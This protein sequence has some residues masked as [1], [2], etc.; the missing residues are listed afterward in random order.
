[1]VVPVQIPKGAGR[2]IVLRIV[3]TTED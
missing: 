3:I 1:V 2:E